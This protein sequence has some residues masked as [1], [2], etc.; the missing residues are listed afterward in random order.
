MHDGGVRPGAVA[1]VR[2]MSARIERHQAWVY[3]GSILA[4]L[5]V[6]SVLPGQAGALEVL[7]WPVLGL[8]LYATFTQ[9]ALT[10]L[11]AALRDVRFV[12]V[13]LVGNFVVIPLVVWALLPL[14]GPDHAVRLGVLL[15]L[16]VPCTDWFVTFA[17]LA[18]GDTR[19]AI[20]VTPLNLIVQLVL[21]PVY[22]WLFLGETFA[23]I[24]TAGRA[25]VVF[26]TLI[27]G[28]LAAAWVTRWATVRRGRGEGLLGRLGR[29]PVLLLAV[30]VFLIAASQVVVVVEAVGL[31]PRLL[32]VYAA[33]LAA[34]A[35]IG[36]ALSRL[37]RLDA[38]PARA[39]VFSLGTRNSFVVLPFAL[40]LPPAFEVAVVVIVFQSLVELF[41][42]VTY[43]RLVP[44]LTPAAEQVR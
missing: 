9:V 29:L 34:A 12:A 36:L 16:L 22:L 42:M 19:R 4:G 41:G 25:A 43:L 33:F 26:T 28:P 31:L 23:E 3:L 10:R 44:R 39:V 27:V 15:V 1:T 18:G 14:A 30:V 20:A 6:G 38:H 35:A 2:A 11:P 5:T 21:L 17:H 24:I 8:L 13:V 32:A 37:A 40:A 7:V